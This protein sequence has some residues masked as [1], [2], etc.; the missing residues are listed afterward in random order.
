MVRPAEKSIELA[1]ANDTI[2]GIVGWR[3]VMTQA[4]IEAE[5]ASQR[6]QL[7]QMQRQQESR[8]NDRRR[9][10]KVVAGM[11]ILYAATGMVFSLISLLSGSEHSAPAPLS[12]M[13]IA[14]SLPLVFLA[15]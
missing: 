14:T 7:L 3:Q 1:H 10:A 11:A 2:R 8:E 13:F 9:L 12:G 4:E 6:Q 5:L 15:I